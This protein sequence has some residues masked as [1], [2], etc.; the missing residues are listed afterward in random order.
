MKRRLLTLC[1]TLSQFYC[2]FCLEREVFGSL[3]EQLMINSGE[4]E[5]EVYLIVVVF[6]TLF[7]VI[8]IHTNECRRYLQ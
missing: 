1:D 3:M 4:S 6:V 2:I 5:L 8:C 7:V